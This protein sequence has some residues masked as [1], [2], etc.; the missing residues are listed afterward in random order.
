MGGGKERTLDFAL[1]EFT[2]LF[3]KF[4]LN[5]DSS[6]FGKIDATELSCF[7]FVTCGDVL[8]MP[9]GLD[10]LACGWSIRSEGPPSSIKE[11]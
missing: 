11:N 1:G 4:R 9:L 6:N 3:L 10:D 2:S 8:K 7:A 5:S